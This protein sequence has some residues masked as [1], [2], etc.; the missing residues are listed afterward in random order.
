MK[1]SR[2]PWILLPLLF[3]LCLIL[4]WNSWQSIRQARVA[5]TEV[6]DIQAQLAQQQPEH[7]LILA[8][9]S[10]ALADEKLQTLLDIFCVL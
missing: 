6:S 4:L 3:V 7:E 5:Q 1:K 8:Q 2:L 10:Q 9:Q